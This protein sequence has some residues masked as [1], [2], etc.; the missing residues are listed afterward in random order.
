MKAVDEEKDCE[1]VYPLK[2]EV[3]GDEGGGGDADESGDFG[4]FGAVLEENLEEAAAVEGENGDEV[5][6]EPPNVDAEGHVEHVMHVVVR[7][8]EV[9][10]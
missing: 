3:R 9:G 10:F 4:S 1:E 8:E 2:E 6:E 5:K 7:M